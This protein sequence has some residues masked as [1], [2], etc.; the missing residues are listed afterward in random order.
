MNLVIQQLEANFITP[1]IVGGK[2]SVNALFAFIGL[3]VGGIFWGVA[4]M[5]LAIPLTAIVKTV[6]YYIPETQKFS[7][8][9]SDDFPSKSFEDY[10]A[11]YRKFKE[12]HIV[13]ESK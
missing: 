8:L 6:T 13:S 4:G 10:L 11:G 12:T 7:Y 3:L 1:K 9:L 5:I 2:V